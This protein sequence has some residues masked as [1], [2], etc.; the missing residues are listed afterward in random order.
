MKWIFA[1]AALIILNFEAHAQNSAT[2]LLGEYN[3]KTLET[4]YLKLFCVNLDPEGEQ[5]KEN[6]RSVNSVPGFKGFN[7]SKHPISENPF[8]IKTIQNIKTIYHTRGVHGE[9]RKVS[10]SFLIPQLSDPKKIRGV[11]LFF[12]PTILGKYNVPS[13]NFDS[14]MNKML[15]SVFASQGYI[16][17]TPDYIGL[18]DDDTVAHPYIIYPKANTDDAL[19]MLQVLRTYLE[20][21]GIAKNKNLNLFVSS[22]SEGGGYALWFSKLAQNQRT[23]YPKTLATNRYDLKH[24]AGISG[25]YNYSDIAKKWFFSTTTDA[26]TAYHIS[27]TLLTTASKSSLVAHFIVSY[28]YYNENKQYQKFI[29]PDFFNMKCGFFIFGCKINGNSYDLY[30][31]SSAKAKESE[32][33]GAIFN[34]ARGKSNNDF[35]YKMFPT[36]ENNALALISKNLLENAQFNTL[37]KQA[38]IDSWKSDIPTTFIYLAQDS[39]VTNLQST[40]AFR[41]M[42]QKGS[43]HIDKVEFDTDLLVGVRPHVDHIKGMYYLMIPALEKFNQYSTNH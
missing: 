18:G 20:R 8:G 31:V 17:A 36:T 40:T 43:K 25:A 32:I 38:D 28:V 19:S 2:A 22:Y 41:N 6:I 37:L 12:H 35:T 5:C 7:L 11:I 9:L 39:I 21:N 16:V 33:G 13:Y 14:P 1:L 3:T 27:S 29:D 10:G 42:I 4:D 34:S 24:V 30:S 23:I 26:D 15:A